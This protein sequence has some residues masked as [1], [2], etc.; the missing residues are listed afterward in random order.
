MAANP[1]ATKEVIY[2]W[3]GK[4]K[5]GKIVK[6]EMKASGESFVSATLRR[7]GITVTNYA[8]KGLLSPKL[9]NKAALLILVKS[10]I[11]TSRYLHAN[12]R[13]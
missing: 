8:A 11:K 2:T 10:Q 3:V 9:K 12:S 6:G 4:D 5:K 7:Q 13:P 1:K